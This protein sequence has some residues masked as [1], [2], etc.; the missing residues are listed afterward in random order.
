MKRVERRG[1]ADASVL[2]QNL[3]MAHP[4][5][6][7]SFSSQTQ[8]Q[9][10]STQSTQVS[11]TQLGTQYSPQRWQNGRNYENGGEKRYDVLPRDYGKRD[12]SVEGKGSA[13]KEKEAEKDA[14]GEVA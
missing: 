6:Q 14:E 1:T 12:G 10:P 9:P 5:P 3:S 7:S 8:P 11:Q 4:A 13:A 2:A